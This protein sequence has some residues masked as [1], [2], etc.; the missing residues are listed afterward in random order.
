[1]RIPPSLERCV[2]LWLIVALMERDI[3][4]TGIFTLGHR[5]LS[6]IDLKTGE[7]PIYNED[8]TV[9]VVYNG[10]IYNFRVLRA[11]LESRGH[12]FSTETDT[13]V[14]VHAYEEYG[15]DCLRLFNGMF[16]FA[17]YDT[18]KKSL[19]LARDR[20]GIKPLHYTFL[21]DGT[22]LFAS[23]IKA[24]LQYSRVKTGDKSPVSPL[25]HQ[26]QIYPWRTNDVP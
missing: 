7:Q 19:F 23:E 14:I 1:M 17:L 2:I 9:V 24:L 22:F 12:R 10:E 5:R 11:E 13:E 4:L 8:R 26:P 25:Y 15:Y 21:K 18:A 16:A 20:S 3:F 6:I